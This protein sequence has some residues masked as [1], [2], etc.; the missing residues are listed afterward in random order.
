MHAQLLNPDGILVRQ[1]DLPKDDFYRLPALPQGAQCIP[2]LLAGD[3]GPV[4]E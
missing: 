2:R 4:E 1:L 3:V